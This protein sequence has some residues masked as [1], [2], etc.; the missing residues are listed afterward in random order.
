MPETV[1][2]RVVFRRKIVSCSTGNLKFAQT[3]LEK[4]WRDYRVAHRCESEQIRVESQQTNSVSLLV[5]L[6][7]K[8]TALP[9][10]RWHAD[11]SRIN[12]R[13]ILE[14]VDK[15]ANEKA[16]RPQENTRILYRTEAY[17]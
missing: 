12:R 3:N 9:E 10:S 7:G 8:A 6:Q 1:T 16:K 17:N 5:F 11:T 4:E 15:C 2:V 13:Q 14:R